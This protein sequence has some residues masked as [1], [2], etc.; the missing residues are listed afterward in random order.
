VTAPSIRMETVKK[1]RSTDACGIV[2]Q[3][4]WQTSENRVSWC[5]AGRNRL[6]SG[7]VAFV[8]VGSLIITKDYNEGL[9]SGHPRWEK[10]EYG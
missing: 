10:A 3:N 6:Q 7:I 8:N 5:H 9:F 2:E 4:W 1:V